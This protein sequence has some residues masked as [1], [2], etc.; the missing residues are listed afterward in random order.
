M[1]IGY[2]PFGW[3]L[4][5]TFIDPGRASDESHPCAILRPGDEISSPPRGEAAPLLVRTAD[6]ARLDVLLVDGHIAIRDGLRILLERRGMNVVGCVESVDAA[7]QAVR[8]SQPAVVFIDS[9]LPEESSAHL[10]RVLRRLHPDTASIL[11]AGFRSPTEI[12]VLLGA[13]VD[14]LVLK[15]SPL[16]RVVDGIRSVARGTSYVDPVATAL[17][18][19]DEEDGLL[20]SRER[21]VFSLL[22]L[23]YSGEDIAEELVLS[24]E[25]IR[26]HIRN[27]MNKLNAHTRAGAVAAAL[28]R[29]EVRPPGRPA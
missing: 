1:K 7:V 6:S 11:Y 22:A 24:P 2:A 18:R 26:T 13:G 12:S 25:T 28:A 10:V 23:D 14:G 3:D 4:L 17:L 20:S 21:Q 5:C 29:N 19:A 15:T 9:D 8:E 16:D 27:G